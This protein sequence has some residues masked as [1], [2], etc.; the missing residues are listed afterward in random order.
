MI[1]S[2]TI[3]IA[4][5]MTPICSAIPKIQDSNRRTATV[6][7]TETYIVNFTSPAARNPLLRAPENGNAEALNRLWINTRWMTSCF[8]SGSKA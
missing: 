5:P 6:D 4:I 3:A 8:V 7:M 1:Q 2:Q